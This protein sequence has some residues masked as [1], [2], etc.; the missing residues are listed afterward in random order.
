MTRWRIWNAKSIYALFLVHL[1]SMKA[2]E[3]EHKR[4]QMNRKLSAQMN[5][6]CISTSI[7]LT[8]FKTTHYFLW[9]YNTKKPDY[10]FVFNKLK[11]LCKSKELKGIDAEIDNCICLSQTD[12]LV[13]SYLPKS[14]CKMRPCHRLK[15][16]KSKLCVHIQ[17]NFHLWVLSKTKQT[18][19]NPEFLRF[20]FILS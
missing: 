18:K 9:D 13:H 19:K 14:K 20:D 11:T 5:K 16:I 15:W 6:H 4:A 7:V 1:W 10:Y 3:N 12:K 8:N 2:G 17:N